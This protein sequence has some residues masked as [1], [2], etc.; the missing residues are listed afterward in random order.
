MDKLINKT[1]NSLETSTNEVNEERVVRTK[2]NGN[3]LVVGSSSSAL[4][5]RYA[6]GVSFGVCWQRLNENKNC[7]SKTKTI[8]AI[9]SCEKDEMDKS[10]IKIEKNYQRRACD[11]T[12]GWWGSLVA[13]PKLPWY[14]RAARPRFRPGTGGIPCEARPV[15]IL[16]STCR[17]GCRKGD[18]V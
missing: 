9:D 13:V 14:T 10:K 15:C 18:P 8:V 2:S 3:V 12:R 4:A 11:E 16:N 17:S 6:S 1:E 5:V 7:P